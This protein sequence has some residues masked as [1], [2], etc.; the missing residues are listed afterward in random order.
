MN[1]G[2]P[3]YDE[4]RIKD[5]L[6]RCTR[7]RRVAFSC[8]VA[9]RLMATYEWFTIAADQGDSGALRSALDLAWSVAAGEPAALSDIELARDVAVSLVPDDQDDNWM[10]LSPLAQNAAASVAYALRSS[11]VDDPQEAVWAA[12]Q[13][14]EA[15]DYLV[16]LTGPEQTYEDHPSSTPMSIAVGGIETA[17]ACAVSAPVSDLRTKSEAD[18]WRLRRLL[19]AGTEE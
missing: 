16:Q 3:T 11:L 5:Q 9:E 18:G 2:T 1:Q 12:R 10:I 15:A 7:A 14:H 19:E 8:A 6:A 4:R 17:L 13:L